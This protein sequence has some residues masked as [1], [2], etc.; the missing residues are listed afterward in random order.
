MA[1][2]RGSGTPL[3][4]LEAVSRVSTD[5]VQLLCLLFQPLHFQISSLEPVGIQPTTWRWPD[6]P[7][8]RMPFFF[9]SAEQG[10]SMRQ[11]T[12]HSLSCALSP[13]GQVPGPWKDHLPRA[14]SPSCLLSAEA[15]TEA[16]PMG[17]CRDAA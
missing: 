3:P 15:E 16:F 7:G 13:Q 9:H 11:G 12:V 8:V 4:F 5:P 6:H 1:L 14:L 17:L 2:L 10:L